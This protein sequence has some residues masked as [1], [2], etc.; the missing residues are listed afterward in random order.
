MLFSGR[1]LTQHVESVGFHPQS[2][3]HTHAHTRVYT[4]I[5][6]GRGTEHKWDKMLKQENLPTQHMDVCVLILSFANFRN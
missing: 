2:R 6:T 5:M 1:L 3:T 4:Q